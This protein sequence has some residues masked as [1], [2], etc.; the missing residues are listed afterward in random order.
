M[1]EGLQFTAEVKRLVAPSTHLPSP[2]D[3]LELL[4]QLVVTGA[5]ARSD[6]THACAAAI[7][8]GWNRSKNL[9]NTVIKKGD[10]KFWSWAE[11]EIEH[12]TETTLKTLQIPD[13]LFPLLS[14]KMSPFGTVMLRGSLLAPPIP[15]EELILKQAAVSAL[16][17]DKK[18]RKFITRF[19]DQLDNLRTE[20]DICKK[21]SHLA[22]LATLA[23]RKLPQTDNPV[24]QNLLQT[25]TEYFN[26]AVV[27]DFL[28]IDFTA[29]H[30]H[31][32]FSR[33][34]DS[35]I[36]INPIYY[37]EAG[38]ATVGLIILSGLIQVCPLIFTPGYEIRPDVNAFLLS[39]IAVAGLIT[40]IEGIY[41]K[42]KL[43]FLANY[44]KALFSSDKYRNMVGAVAALEEMGA[45]ASI[46][47]SPLA[48]MPEIPEQGDTLAIDEMGDL[49]ARLRNQ[50]VVPNNLELRKGVPLTETGQNGGGKTFFPTLALRNISISMI[51]GPVI[52]KNASIPY[53]T[54]WAM[55]SAK[56][57]AHGGH[58]RLGSEADTTGHLLTQA[59]AHGGRAVLVFD[60]V[61]GGG[62]RTSTE[63]A[64]LRALGES[65]AGG[66]WAIHPTHEL[67][68][69]K[70][71]NNAG[72]IRAIRM[73]GTG[74]EITH[75]FE[76]G[77][78][79][80]SGAW[81]IIER[82]GYDVESTRARV[83]EA[84]GDLELFDRWIEVGRQLKQ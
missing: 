10:L 39:S 58:G 59:H 69:T 49:V 56:Q 6:I 66:M 67:P 33:F 79:E 11:V 15:Y 47:D 21:Q 38:V 31:N 44:E 2:I 80:S 74:A 57:E 16:S 12:T 70:K 7:E 50:K 30:A 28:K 36:R 43:K 48:S 4:E 5:S 8:R 75:K 52:G 24:V 37:E 65:A 53:T 23:S 17:E 34:R 77:V 84:N 60:E 55:Q 78:A 35:K 27:I 20:K 62:D 19:S 83:I 3:R 72:L 22:K 73:K 45:L 46:L 32:R 14:D 64:T 82:I 18:A 13:T 1:S 71:L 63:D 26:Q 9:H 68:I 54:Y 41:H 40:G 76:D 81:I 25:I 61:G 29:T 51:G 42:R